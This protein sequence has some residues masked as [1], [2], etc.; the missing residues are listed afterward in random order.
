MD[1]MMNDPDYREHIGEEIADTLF[2]LLRFCAKYN[3]TPGEI[4][5]DK[6]EKNNKKY[7]VNTVK[8][9]NLKRQEYKMEG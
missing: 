9:K 3:F 6:I 8:G 5:V 7:P 2:F 4:L 1:K